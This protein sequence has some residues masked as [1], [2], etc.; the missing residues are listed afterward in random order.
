MQ[1]NVLTVGAP[2]RTPARRCEPENESLLASTCIH[3]QTAVH[4]YYTPLKSHICT[5]VQAPFPEWDLLR[6]LE[7]KRILEPQFESP[8]FMELSLSPEV[9]STFSII[10]R[11]LSLRDV[12]RSIKPSY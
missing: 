8:E 5:G 2:T 7:P 11:Q 6:A 3:A 4:P 9:S 1:C 12:L 10:L